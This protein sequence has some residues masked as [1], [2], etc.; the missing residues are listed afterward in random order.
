MFAFPALIPTYLNPVVDKAG[1]IVVSTVRTPEDVDRQI[2]DLVNKERAKAGVAPLA[3]NEQAAQTAREYSKQMYDSGVFEHSTTFCYGENIFMI[4][5]APVS[6]WQ[7]VNAW[8]ESPGH[9][10]NILDP[11]YTSEG[12]GVFGGYVTQ[13][14][15]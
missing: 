10:Q 3:W 15:C 14:F 2:H 6:A 4:Q 1:D 9:K 12:I 11:D 5:G 7:T 13:N 8:M